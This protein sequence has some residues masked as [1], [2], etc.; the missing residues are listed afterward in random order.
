MTKPDYKP[1]RF[2]W[3]CGRKLW[4]VKKPVVQVVEGLPRTMH[5]FCSEHTDWVIEQEEDSQ[6]ILDAIKRE[7][8]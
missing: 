7:E 3:V 4:N 8:L 6:A 5:K 2:C 1:T